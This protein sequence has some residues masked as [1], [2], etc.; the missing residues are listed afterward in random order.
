LED[1]SK[2]SRSFFDGQESRQT[3]QRKIQQS[4]A[5]GQTVVFAICPAPERFVQMQT[6]HYAN[7][8]SIT[9][10]SVQGRWF[11]GIVQESVGN[12]E[13]KNRKKEVAGW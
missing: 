7:E 9:I 11:F 10:Q 2:L 6:P 4:D 3:N 12:D 5:T 1:N 13:Q 8:K